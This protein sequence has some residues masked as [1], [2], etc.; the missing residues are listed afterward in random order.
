[1]SRDDEPTG[2]MHMDGNRDEVWLRAWMLSSPANTCGVQPCADGTL[3]AYATGLH[4]SGARTS[5][6]TAVGDESLAKAM[7]RA[8]ELLNR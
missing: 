1:M 6:S 2:P 4:P 3:E 7:R 5:E 8:A